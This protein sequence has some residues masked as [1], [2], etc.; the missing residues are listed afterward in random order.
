MAKAP[1]LSK[2]KQVRIPR[3]GES[4]KITMVRTTPQGLWYDV[5]VSS[6]PK[7]KLIKSFRAASLELVV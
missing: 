1:T 7:Q 3:T 4:G 2:N 5:N 6:D